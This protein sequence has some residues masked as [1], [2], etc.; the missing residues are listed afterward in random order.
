MQTDINLMD[1]LSLHLRGRLAELRKAR[2]EGAKIVGYIPGG[3]MPE[4]LVLASGAIPICLVRGGDHSA[5]NFAGAYIC[6]WIDPFCRAQIGYGVSGDDPYY[7]IT[8][9]LVIPMTDNH[10]RSIMDVLDYHTDM[11]IFPFGVPHMK[12]ESTNNYYLHGIT[13]LKNKL[14]ETTGVRITESKLRETIDLCNRERELLRK[15]S[16]LRKSDAV[17]LTGSD[18]VALNH[19]SFFVNKELMVGI[20]ESLYKKLQGQDTAAAKGPRI[21]FTG[22]TLALGDSVVLNMIEEAGGMI[23][24]EEFAEGLRPYWNDVTPEKD[25]MK[26]L[27]D[28]Y[29]MKRTPPAWFRP[30][31][32]RLDF[33]VNLAREFNV[34]G[35]VW[36]HLMYRE[37]YKLESYYFQDKL[38]S[39][40]GLPMLT[41]ESEYDPSE[42]GQIRTRIETFM[43]TLRR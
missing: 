24:V 41:L 43:E 4:E 19:G 39:E 25:P 9:L 38:K 14:E 7:N 10:I 13:R 32:E 2:G 17:S 8:D 31:K 30:G 5:V 6:R 15:I 11:E 35:V 21:L 20:L 3:Y 27:A 40:T 28:S 23:V 37:S 26:A 36:Y 18:F 29:F 22:S 1:E 42:R 34:D 12:D 16:L 33:L